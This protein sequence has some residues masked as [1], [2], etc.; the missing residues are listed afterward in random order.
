M[1]FLGAFLRSVVFSFFHWI[2]LRYSAMASA[3][4]FGRTLFPLISFC[5]VKVGVNFDLQSLIPCH[6]SFRFA[7][8]SSLLMVWLILSLSA[9]FLISLLS[10]F[11]SSLFPSLLW[12]SLCSISFHVS[13]L[14]YDCFCF[15]SMATKLFFCCGN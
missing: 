4:F 3:F 9:C 13:L 14:I 8:C 10:F 5:L 1:I 2:S 12:A 15:G 11:S 7:A 6:L